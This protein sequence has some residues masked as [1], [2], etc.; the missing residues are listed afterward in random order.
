M[1]SSGVSGAGFNTTVQPARRAGTVFCTAMDVGIVPGDPLA[2]TNPYRLL[3]HERAPESELRTSRKG[4]DSATLDVCVEDADG[5]AT[6]MVRDWVIGLPICA[7]IELG[8][9]LAGER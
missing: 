6:W 2:A 1:K 5:V 9:F 8:E 7:V 3:Y 4:Y